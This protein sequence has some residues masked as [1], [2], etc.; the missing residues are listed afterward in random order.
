[1]DTTT[2]DQLNSYQGDN[3]WEDV[4]YQLAYSEEATNRAYITADRNPSYSDMA[5]IDGV[6]YRHN[7]AQ[8]AV[9]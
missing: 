2:L 5:V 3:I 9:V 7:G 4:I 8:W 6:T 1:M